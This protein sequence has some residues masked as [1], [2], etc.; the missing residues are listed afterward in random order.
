MKMTHSLS[1]LIKEEQRILSQPPP[2]KFSSL[3]LTQLNDMFNKY[4]LQD[5]ELAGWRWEW[6]TTHARE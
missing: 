6:K 3:K 2:Q 5:Y 4:L 1:C